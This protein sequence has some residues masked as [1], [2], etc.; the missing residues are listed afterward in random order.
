MVVIKP[1]NRL[2]Y[3]ILLKMI[4]FNFLEEMAFTGRHEVNALVWEKRE[5]L[6][7]GLNELQS[8][9]HILPCC[10][11]HSGRGVGPYYRLEAFTKDD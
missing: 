3:R 6:G 4:S 1:M 7:M 11:K 2:G 9:I 10:F 5:L 8:C